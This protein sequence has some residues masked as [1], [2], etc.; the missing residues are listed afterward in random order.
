[1]SPRCARAPSHPDRAPSP[2]QRTRPRRSQRGNQ[3]QRLAVRAHLP[4]RSHFRRQRGCRVRQPLRLR[5]Q[6]HILRDPSANC[7]SSA[8]RRMFLIRLNAAEIAAKSSDP[9]T[10]VSAS[11]W[12]SR[13]AHRSRPQ[14]APRSPRH[15]QSRTRPSDRSAAAHAEMLSQVPIGAFSAARLH[16]LGRVNC[17]FDSARIFTIAFAARRRANGSFEPVGALPMPNMAV[18]SESCPQGPAPGLR[19]LKESRLQS[20]RPY[21]S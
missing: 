18:M 16:Y 17:N 7:F 6:R 15:K 10:A 9:R 13:R 4:Q 20:M 21:W 19:Q 14:P 8:C 11:A 5:R 2:C 3:R 1:M 12:R